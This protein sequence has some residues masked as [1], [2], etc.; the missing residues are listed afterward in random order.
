M[1][2]YYSLKMQTTRYVNDQYILFQDMLICLS[3]RWKQIAWQRPLSISRLFQVIPQER[4]WN[5][6]RLFFLPT[7]L[8]FVAVST[9]NRV[10]HL[11]PG[12]SHKKG[13]GGG[14]PWFLLGVRKAVTICFRLFSLKTSTVGAFAELEPVRSENNFKVHTK[15][16]W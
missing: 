15:G 1:Q 12:D 8:I 10:I 5:T 9:C 16:S 7:E 4:R 13:R 6:L 3:L 11:I 2:I 14:V